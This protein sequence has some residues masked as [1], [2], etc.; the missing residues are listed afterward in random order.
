MYTIRNFGDMVGDANRFEAY[1]KAISATVRPGDAVLEIGCGPAVFSF[2]A[3][4]AG[5]R[6]VYAIETEE[7]VNLAKTLCTENGLAD[8]VQFIQR[9]SRKT[10]LPERVKVIISDIRGT[11]PF[12]DHAIPSIND[13]RERFLL[14]DGIVIPQ[15]D[16]LKVVVVDAREFYGSITS[17]WITSVPSL[18]LSAALPS[19][20]NSCHSMRF[21]DLV[22]LAVPQTWCVLDYGRKTPARA[23]GEMTFVVTRKGIGHGLCLWFDT[24]LFEN[25]GF[26]AGPGGEAKI[27]GQLFLPWAEHVDLT[28]GQEIHVKLD[29]DLVGKD[30][31]WRWETDISLKDGRPGKHFRQS[32]FEGADLSPQSL[33]RH[34]T[35][36]V[37]VLTEEGEADRFLLQEMNGTATLQQISEK[38]AERFPNVYPGS[39]EAFQRAA[40]LARQFSR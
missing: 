12:F 6:R 1:A 38:A 18:K 17:P 20:L 34:A 7:V 32:T 36:H 21:K 19:V 14:P 16:T 31:I 10:V 35:S 29:A 8:R 30:Y 4:Q 39:D 26:S 15:R 25:I 28:E 27:Y 11:L 37:P 3:C 22:Q 2:L 5:A 9:D 33:R 24:V 23:G 13:A 40:E